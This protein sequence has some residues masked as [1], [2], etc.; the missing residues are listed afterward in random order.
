MR[1]TEAGGRG[2][3]KGPPGR[4]DLVLHCPSLFLSFT[5][6]NV[7]DAFVDTTPTFNSIVFSQSLHPNIM[8]SFKFLSPYSFVSYCSSNF[9]RTPR[10]TRGFLFFLFYSRNGA[11]E[12]RSQCLRLAYKKEVNLLEAERISPASASRQ[13]RS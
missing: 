10:V 3:E 2:N 1:R 8:A 11:P 12:R 7:T 13:T 6:A 5:Q 4:D 9:S